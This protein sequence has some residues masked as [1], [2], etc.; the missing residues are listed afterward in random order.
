MPIVTRRYL[1]EQ[2]LYRIKDGNPTVASTVKL[3][4]I[5]P[6]IAQVCNAAFKME[7]FSVNMA[8][9]QT[10]PEGL[11]LATYDNI[12]VSPYK[13]VSKSVLPVMPIALPRNMGIFNIYPL[14]VDGSYNPKQPIIPFEAGQEAFTDEL[15]SELITLSY[16]PH[17]TLIQY[18][19]D[20]NLLGITDVLMRLVVMDIDAYDDYTLLPI[21]A[22]MVDGI[23]RK[24]T[25]FFIGEQPKDR[26]VDSGAER[27]T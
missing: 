11:M 14:A 25:E 21:P 17:G 19:T 10:I 5:R 9:G 22:D 20:L 26:I 7:Q 2:V 15:L 23:I 6:Q 18:N 8:T 16:V 3:Q 27:A 4:D 12:A 24:V 13:G 1:S